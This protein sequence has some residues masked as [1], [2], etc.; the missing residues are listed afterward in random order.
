LSLLLL[1]CSDD[2][3]LIIPIDSA[4]VTQND[5]TLTE[6]ETVTLEVAITP[7]NTTEILYY[8][9]STIY[10]NV[11]MTN[12]ILKITGKKTGVSNV[13][14]KNEAGNILT[15]IK[16]TVIPKQYA[17]NEPIIKDNGLCAVVESVFHR[18]SNTGVIY[19]N[20][21]GF[22]GQLLLIAKVSF[23]NNSA[24][25]EYVSSSYFGLTNGYQQINTINYS[26]NYD[27]DGNSISTN[28]AQTIQ[29][30]ARYTMYIGFEPTLETLLVEDEYK[31][32]FEKYSLAFNVVFVDED[33]E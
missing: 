17:L 13:S 22:P 26:Y 20:S 6:G 7:T 24:S 21:S 2:N 10:L 19:S 3:L 23:E 25:S 5:V 31:L 8:S 1:S 28:V 14:I 30:G 16:V 33:I 32:I 15:S 4:S 18:R 11:S 29:P 9:Y 27:V 12:R